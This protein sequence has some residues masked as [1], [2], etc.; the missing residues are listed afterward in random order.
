MSIDLPT[1]V[2]EQL[3]RLA[4]KQGRDVSALVHEALRHYIDRLAI[5][6]VDVSEIAETQA[7]LVAELPPMAAWKADPL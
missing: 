2:E 5:T 4:T 3:R 1:S 7:A 6:D